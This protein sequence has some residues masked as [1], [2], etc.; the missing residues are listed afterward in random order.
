MQRSPP[1]DPSDNNA[2]GFAAK[3]TCGV[4]N[5]FK[6]CV[7]AFNADDGWDL[8]SKTATG[9]IG[10][11]KIYDSI[12]YGNGFYIDADGEVKATAGDGNGFKMGG[13]GL[14]VMHEAYNCISFGNKTNGF[15]NNSDP[16]GKYID[17]MGYNNGGSNLELH[18]YTGAEPQFTVT[19]FKSFADSTYQ[20]I[21]TDIAEGD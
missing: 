7:A 19:N 18:V 16:M 1:P 9:P 17:C 4:G 15:T 13:S 6:Y 2:D 10:E 8:F 12:C 14:A 11:V 21:S 20:N 3:L 5:V